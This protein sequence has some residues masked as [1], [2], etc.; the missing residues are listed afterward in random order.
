MP[1]VKYKG[2]VLIY[3]AAQKHHIGLYVFP[4]TNIEFADSLKYYKTGKG[5]IQ[6]SN[7]EELPM[8]LIS[9]IIQFRIDTIN[10]M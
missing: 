10:N 5:S 6:F 2:S 3:F 8:A 4:E 9:E 7:N 1:T